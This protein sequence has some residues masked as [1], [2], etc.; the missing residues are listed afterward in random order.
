MMTNQMQ[1]SLFQ[2]SPQHEHPSAELLVFR[3][4]VGLE[5]HGVPVAVV[6]LFI[7]TGGCLLVVFRMWIR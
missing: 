7:T 6:T 3:V 4:P 5:E 2:I 1:N